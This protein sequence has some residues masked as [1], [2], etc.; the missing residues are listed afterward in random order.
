MTQAIPESLHHHRFYPGQGRIRQPAGILKARHLGI[1]ADV[2][3]VRVCHPDD[4]R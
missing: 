1:V 2:A 4:G 3:Q